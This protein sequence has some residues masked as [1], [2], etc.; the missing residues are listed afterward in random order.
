VWA[1]WRLWRKV[2]ESGDGASAKK[3]RNVMR[4]P[5]IFQW[6]EAGVPITLIVDLLD[7]GG[8]DSAMILR[9]EPSDLSWI[10][11]A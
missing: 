8:P 9:A 1:L 11:A 2:D 5:N 3:E 10:P 7:A 6:L 4:L